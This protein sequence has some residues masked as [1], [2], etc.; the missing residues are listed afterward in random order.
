VASASSGFLE[1]FAPDHFLFSFHGVPERHIKRVHPVCLTSAGC[2]DQISAANFNC[3]RAQ[4][5]QTARSVAKALRIPD[6]QYSV[7][8]Q[9]RLG[10]TPW[11]RPYTDFVIAELPSK[12]VK[13]VAVFCLSFVAD[14]L[15]TL[16]EITNRE[17]E[18]FLNSG[19]RELRLIPSLND[20]PDW[21][22]AASMIIR[23]ALDS[24]SAS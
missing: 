15:E 21:I 9:S 12:G 17:R 2:C 5:F 16:D 8:F 7:A 13:T 23:K 18:R 22:R 24:A 3:Y 14:C 20:H 19:G 1:N 10:R 6:M 4:C 11:I